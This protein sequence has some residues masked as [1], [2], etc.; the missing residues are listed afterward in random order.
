[1]AA[2]LREDAAELGVSI[3]VIEGAW[4]EVD[5][6][7]E[8]VDVAMSAHVV[9]DVHEI[10]Q[11]LGAM[12]YKAQTAVV[13]ELSDRHP[14][15]GLAPYYRA[16]HGLDRPD[17]PTAEDLLEVVSAMLERPPQ[18]ERWRRR[19][20]LSFESL[21]EI[22]EVFGRRLVLPR[23]RWNELDDVLDVTE[24]DGLFFV[25]DEQRDLVTIWW[26]VLD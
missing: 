5:V 1:M 10:E 3:E 16:L 20:G 21:D 12:Q 8:P 9:Y 11:F 24:V 13:I 18:V 22:R 4:P 7:V 14:W 17:G 23:S 2:G 25:G 6:R 26:R 19:G 15:A